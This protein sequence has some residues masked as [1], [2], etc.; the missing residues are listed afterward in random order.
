M[1]KG[2]AG[3]VIL[4]VVL[5]LLLLS[6][7]TVFILKP[8]FL[9]K[10]KE[11]KNIIYKEFLIKVKDKYSL[12]YVDSNVSIYSS[13]GLLLYNLKTQNDSF[14]KVNLSVNDITITKHKECKNV[15]V[16]FSK[17]LMC[18]DKDLPTPLIYSS[19][20]VVVERE[21]YYSSVIDLNVSD[22]TNKVTELELTPGAELKLLSAD[23][24]FSGDIEDVYSF[25]VYLSYLDGDLKNPTICLSYSLGI[26]KSWIDNSNFMLF[27]DDKLSDYTRCYKVNQNFVSQGNY[28]FDVY[29]TSLNL[30]NN[31]Y[32]RVCVL[33]SDFIYKENKYFY[34]YNNKDLGAK[35]YCLNMTLQ[36]SG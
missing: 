28:N 12:N 10:N 30:F 16:V 8:S 7:I 21:G 2:K 14:E 17:K 24:L 27:D 19:Y 35:N 33:D 11:N 23:K 29:Y 13:E 36:G 34:F 9:F 4:V 22:T 5:I 20:K 32:V 31:D 1:S 26:L 18:E 25:K 3:L 15:S 6:I